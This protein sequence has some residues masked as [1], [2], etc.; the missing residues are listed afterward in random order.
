MAMNAS[1]ALLANVMDRADVGMVERGGGAGLTFESFE[2]LW[3]VC[4]IFWQE[5]QGDETP[6]SRVFGLVDHTHPATTELFDDAVMRDGLPQ[7]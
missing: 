2:R 4:N 5:L 3:V 1:A 7:E 6:E